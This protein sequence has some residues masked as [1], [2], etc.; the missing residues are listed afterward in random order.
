LILGG[1]GE[2]VG[3]LGVVGEEDVLGEVEDLD[4]AVV[5]DPVVPSNARLLLAWGQS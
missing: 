2:E 5:D 1:V 4:E 3:P